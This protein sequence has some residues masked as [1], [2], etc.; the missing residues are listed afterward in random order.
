MRN[1]SILHL[2]KE[3]PLR[4]MPVS[5]ANRSEGSGDLLFLLALG[6]RGVLVLLVFRDKIIHVAL[7]L[8]EL[9]LVHALS[10][11]PMQECFASEHSSEL[12]TDTL[13]Q[14]LNRSRISDES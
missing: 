4:C 2:P 12:I 6:D 10:S 8:R 3:L 7:C 9:H 14:L 11:I 1:H 13:E 5:T